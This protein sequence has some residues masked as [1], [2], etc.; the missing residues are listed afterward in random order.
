MTN[1]DIFT[2]IERDCLDALTKRVLNKSVKF[3]YGVRFLDE[4]TGGI[5]M[6]SLIV[7]A[8]KSG[9]GK[10]DL[11]DIIL[12]TNS[13]KGANVYGIFLE[14][15]KG[16]ISN[17][18]LYRE[19][20]NLY[21]T[22]YKNTFNVKKLSYTKFYDGCYDTE[23]PTLM[24]IATKNMKEKNNKLNIYYRDQTKF[25]I[26]EFESLID[27]HIPRNGKPTLLIIDHIHH[28]D[29]ESYND[30]K[31]LKDII[32]KIRDASLLNGFA[33]ILMAH[34]RKTDRKNKVLIP[35]AEEIY[36]SSEIYKEATQV[37]TMAPFHKDSS[38]FYCPTLF[39][40]TKNRTGSLNRYIGLHGFDISRG[41]Y[42]DD[43]YLHKLNY[44]ENE[45]VDITKEDTPDW[46]MQEKKIESSQLEL[47]SNEEGIE[48]INV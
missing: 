40:I 36:G 3:N 23:F 7:V 13:N 38:Q 44:E 6:N 35:D 41:V 33:I 4:A 24:E 5:R 19:F 47:I 15:E 31:A 17:R 46:Y 42:S 28:F 37:I 27:N 43:Y 30:V 22:T 8:A 9:V 34:I 32:K 18:K 26:E 45:L 20:A 10:T 14:A 12:Q 21:Y 2:H 25:G 48:V 29:W 16:E 39:R 11:A 1:V